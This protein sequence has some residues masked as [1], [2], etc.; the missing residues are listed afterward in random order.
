MKSLFLPAVAVTLLFAACAEQ[1]VTPNA[2]YYF[3]SKAQLAAAE[4][5]AFAGDNA[6]ARRVADYYYFARNER[7][8]AMFWLRLAA[9]RGDA[10]AKQNLRQLEG[11]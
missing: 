5:D 4:K 6:A 10:V 7:A 9:L 1:G 11:Q 2:Q 3:K 8:D